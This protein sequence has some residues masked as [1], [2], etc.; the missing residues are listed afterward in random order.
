MAD[1]L[2]KANRDKT[3]LK[4]FLREGQL[5]LVQTEANKQSK[6]L[7]RAQRSRRSADPTKEEMRQRRNA[8]RRE[9]LAQE[10]AAEDSE[11]SQVH[12][13]KEKQVDAHGFC[14]KSEVC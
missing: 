4:T 11:G 6:E 13:D 8:A 14:S 12:G 7:K 2:T 9:Q 10:V 3:G 5:C 1:V